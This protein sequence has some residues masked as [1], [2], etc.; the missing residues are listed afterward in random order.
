MKSLEKANLLKRKVFYEH[1]T[2]TIRQAPENYCLL[3]YKN[4]KWEL[5][6]DKAV[7][8]PDSAILEIIENHHYEDFRDLAD[9]IEILCYRWK[10][11]K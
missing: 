6:K 7:K 2:S 11:Y 3:V 10:H 1:E 8:I 5:F 9:D 4:D